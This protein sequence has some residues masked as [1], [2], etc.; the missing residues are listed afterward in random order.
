MTASL[1]T[2]NFQNNQ[3][4]TEIIDGEP[5]FSLAD[6]RSALSING[7]LK[8]GCTFSEKGI[9]KTR[10]ID[11]MGREQQAT[12]INEP[13]L[14]RLIFRSHKPQAQAF[15]DWVYSEV[16]PSI[17]ETGSYSAPILTQDHEAIKAIGSIVK[18]CTTVAVQEEVAKILTSYPQEAED[19]YYNIG[20]WD[21]V[22]YLQRWYWT[23][24]KTIL[25]AMDDKDEKITLLE[26]KLRKVEKALA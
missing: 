12:F 20:D 17:R 8:K 22:Q 5:W 2:F 14:Y 10:I 1:M 11:S 7:S 25:K 24:H 6:A 13:N 16:L 3:I 21:M 23:R 15:A 4:R 26:S 19:K 9:R 18:K